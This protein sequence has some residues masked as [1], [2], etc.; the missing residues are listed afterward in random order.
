MSEDF[1]IAIIGQAAFGE[2][3]LSSLIKKGDNI[4]GA[5][6]PPQKE[7]KPSDP[8]EAAA[9]E[10]GVAA[11]QFKRMRDAEAIEG[12]RALNADLCVMAF[13]TDI[14]PMEILTAPRL[15]TIQYHPSLLPKFRGPSSI[16]WP[17]IQGGKR[18]P[19]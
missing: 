19:G 14:V 13:V 16:N 1:R 18:R 11:F 2:S 12:F 9:D 3:V 8:M 7:G 6:C 17:I 4:V 10:H 5:F 15:G